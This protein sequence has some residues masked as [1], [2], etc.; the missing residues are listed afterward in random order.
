[1]GEENTRLE[2]AVVSAVT[3]LGVEERPREVDRYQ[4]EKTQIAEELK[5]YLN[6]ALEYES[7][8][9]KQDQ[10]APEPAEIRLKALELADRA[11]KLYETHGEG[12]M[13]DAATAQLKELVEMYGE[14]ATTEVPPTALVGRA[15]VGKD[16]SEAE[17]LYQVAVHVLM[18]VDGRSSDAYQVMLG[19]AARDDPLGFLKDVVVRYADYE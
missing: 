15:C 7:V 4:R 8:R 14:L 10:E 3:D 17:P 18:L 13:F 1:M 2:A 5:G 19:E 6:E 9:E 16:K 11:Q 12:Q